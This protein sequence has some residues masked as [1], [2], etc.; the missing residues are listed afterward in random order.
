MEEPELIPPAGNQPKSFL[1]FLAEQ[2]QGE[3]IV[4]LYLG[5]PAAP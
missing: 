2:Q 5:T 3:L 1:A 4:E